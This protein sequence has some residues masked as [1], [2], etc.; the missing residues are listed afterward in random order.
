MRISKSIAIAEIIGL[1]TRRVSRGES[2]TDR[3]DSTEKE[4]VQFIEFAILQRS[5]IFLER[6]DHVRKAESSSLHIKILFKSFESNLIQPFSSR[7]NLWPEKLRIVTYDFSYYQSGLIF[8]KRS[9]LIFRFSWLHFRSSDLKALGA[10]VL[11]ANSV[12]ASNSEHHSSIIRN[13]SWCDSECDVNQ[14]FTKQFS[15]LP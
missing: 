10:S 11:A 3:T 6:A 14:L 4:R 5:I 15:R 9:L 1:W 13:N 12:L 2:L 7:S 8:K